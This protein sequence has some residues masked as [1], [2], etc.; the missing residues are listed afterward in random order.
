M[1][2][3]LRALGDWHLTFP[4]VFCPL[5]SR[6]KKKR[7]CPLAYKQPPDTHGPLT[8]TAVVKVLR[9]LRAIFITCDNDK[10]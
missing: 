2:T 8:V 6:G 10:V 1:K 9:F 3:H 4:P 5:V 7:H